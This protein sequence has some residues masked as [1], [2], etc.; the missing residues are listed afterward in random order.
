MAEERRERKPIPLAPP[1]PAEQMNMV[2]AEE[3]DTYNKSAQA[4]EPARKVPSPPPAPK[5][6]EAPPAPVPEE[7]RIP[8]GPPL[9]VKLD[10]YQHIVSNIQRLKSY[11]LGLRDGLDAL[12]DIEKEL[13]N[14]ISL[15]NKALD[16]LNSTLSMLDTKLLRVQGIE[17]EGAETP[18]E[19]EEYIKG[20]YKQMEKIKQDLKSM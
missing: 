12:S 18:K 1:F 10:K 5:K 13:Q 15:I 16:N 11:S 20:V 2:M 6:E 3:P 8:A 4:P 7:A 9:F 17:K 19:V 14:G